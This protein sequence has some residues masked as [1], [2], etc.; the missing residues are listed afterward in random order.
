MKLKPKKYR[1]IKKERTEVWK[2]IC[3]HKDDLQFPQSTYKFYFY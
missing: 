2:C 3:C 1:T